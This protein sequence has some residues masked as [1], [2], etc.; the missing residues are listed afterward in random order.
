MAVE[1]Q[2]RRI[3]VSIKSDGDRSLK[4][5]AKGFSEVNKSIKDSTSVMSS[6]RNA[7]LALKGLSFAG[8]GV[9][10]IV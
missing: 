4:T 1:S 2:V 6:F 5:I 9:R 3:E 8:I 7:F 10:E